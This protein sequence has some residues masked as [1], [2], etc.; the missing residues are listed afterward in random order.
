MA[1][2][3]VAERKKDAEKSKPEKRKTWEEEQQSTVRRKKVDIWWREDGKTD[4]EMR[5]VKS[6]AVEDEGRRRKTEEAEKQTKAE[7]AGKKEAVLE[8]EAAEAIPSPSHRGIIDKTAL[9]VAKAGDGYEVRILREMSHARFDFL[10]PN[11][12]YRPY[13]EQKRKRPRQQLQ[14]LKL[15]KHPTPKGRGRQ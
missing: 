4:A 3:E 10:F 5:I 2:K 6:K 7:E 11:H 8:K 9:L 13:Y 1:S 14:R 15:Q 12:L